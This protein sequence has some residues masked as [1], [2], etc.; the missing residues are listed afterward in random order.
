MPDKNQK[1]LPCS[2]QGLQDRGPSE[3]F[4]AWDV[5]TWCKQN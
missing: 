2:K 1:A 3:S 4:T 5:G